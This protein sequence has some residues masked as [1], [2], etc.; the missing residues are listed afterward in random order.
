MIVCYAACCSFLLVLM[1]GC[2]LICAQ[3]VYTHHHNS[4]LWLVVIVIL[5]VSVMLIVL[6]VCCEGIILCKN[7]FDCNDEHD[8]VDSHGP[9]SLTYATVI[10]IFGGSEPNFE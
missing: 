1:A 2:G 8:E 10:N 5:L 4:P 3:D 6:L 9:I 7:G